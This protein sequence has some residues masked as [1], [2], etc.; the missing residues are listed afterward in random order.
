MKSTIKAALIAAAVALPGA[1]AVSAM[2]DTDTM[3]MGQSML[4]GALVNQLS[5]RGI[6]T[7]G[8][9][10]LTLVEVVALR[11]IL[12]DDETPSSTMRSQATHILDEARSR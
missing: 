11:E 4:V 10:N 5:Q 3:A 7:T 12:Q 6:D 9:E 1:S 8:I 2:T